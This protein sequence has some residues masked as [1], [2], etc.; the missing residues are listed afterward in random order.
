MDEKYF[1]DFA[2]MFA[3]DGWRVFIAEMEEML[4]DLDSLYSIKTVE[5]LHYRRGQID[6]LSNLIN[7]QH[8]IQ[9]AREQAEN[10]DN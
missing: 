4:A 5:D 3:S 1:D 2:M 9:A 8:S 6:V 10:E 7:F